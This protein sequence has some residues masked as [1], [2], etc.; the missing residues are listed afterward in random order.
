MREQDLGLDPLEVGGGGG[1]VGYGKGWLD[2]G[3]FC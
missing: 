3:V 2:E 1:N